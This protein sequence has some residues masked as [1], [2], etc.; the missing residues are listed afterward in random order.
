MWKDLQCACH[1]SLRSGSPADF[2]GIIRIP[3]LKT[4]QAVVRLPH[5]CALLNKVSNNLSYYDV[6]ITVHVSDGHK[7]YAGISKQRSGTF[8]E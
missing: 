4:S 1:P 2:W 5:N 7:G 8:G 3:G 6:S